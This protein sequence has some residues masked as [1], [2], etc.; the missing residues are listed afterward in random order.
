MVISEGPMQPARHAPAPQGG[1]DAKGV[2]P[3][4]PRPFLSQLSRRVLSVRTGTNSPLP[5]YVC[6]LL[7]PCA[8]VWASPSGMLRKWLF[9][10][11]TSQPLTSGEQ[12]SVSID[13]K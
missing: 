5:V 13:C 1:E 8:S 10:L 2:G 6:P 4:R 12:P 9:F 11:R 7:G 3:P